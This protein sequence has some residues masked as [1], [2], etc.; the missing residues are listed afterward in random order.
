MGGDPPPPNF[1][2]RY[3]LRI[4]FP[5]EFTSQTKN[6]SR[7][8]GGKYPGAWGGL[9]PPPHGMGGGGRINLKKIMGG[10]WG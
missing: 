5:M 2:R 1:L 9:L 7:V 8:I 3:F 6:L 10:G 4:V